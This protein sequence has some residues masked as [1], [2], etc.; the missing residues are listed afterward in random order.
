[1]SDC[2]PC[3]Q[4]GGQAGGRASKQTPHAHAAIRMDA[5]NHT[6][7]PDNHVVHRRAVSNLYTDTTHHIR[8]RSTVGVDAYAAVGEN[9][10]TRTAGELSPPV[11]VTHT[12]AFPFL[13]F[14]HS[15]QHCLTA[16][17]RFSTF[18]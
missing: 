13:P 2:C 6:P 14:S 7:L 10:A 18:L 11:S 16:H 12:P 15:V 5:I 9:G 4:K 17:K 8:T 3:S 1:M